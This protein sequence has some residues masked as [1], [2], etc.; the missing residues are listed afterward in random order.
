MNNL[1]K[2]EPAFKANKDVLSTTYYVLKDNLFSFLNLL[3]SDNIK[4]PILRT[5][6]MLPDTSCTQTKSKNNLT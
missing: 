1:L 4:P 5:A 6:W 3:Y 2:T